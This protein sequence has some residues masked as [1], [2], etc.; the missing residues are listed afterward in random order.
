MPDQ[1]CAIVSPMRHPR[2]GL[3][4]TV[5][6]GVMFALALSISFLASEAYAI[7]LANA[8]YAPVE[9][10]SPDLTGN[11]SVNRNSRTIEISFPEGE[12]ID[13][14]LQF[15]SS[16]DPPQPS[17]IIAQIG[18]ENITYGTDGNTGRTWV[19]IHFIW[20]STML[21]LENEKHQPTITFMLFDKDQHQ[22]GVGEST[23]F[24]SCRPIRIN[25]RV[26]VDDPERVAFIRV[27]GKSGTWNGEVC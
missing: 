1:E 14:V 11:A 27:A 8:R 2:T 21:F 16:R 15:A 9:I 6:D 7:N 26:F 5:V 10:I 12:S 19:D 25:H 24:T 13:W 17:H 22:I 3:R 20:L 4:H 23:P 18:I